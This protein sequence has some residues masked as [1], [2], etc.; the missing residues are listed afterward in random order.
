MHLYFMEW[1]FSVLLHKVKRALHLLSQMK[2]CPFYIKNGTRAAYIRWLR[3]S[4]FVLS[5]FSS[6]RRHRDHAC[7]VVGWRVV[8]SA[9]VDTKERSK[10]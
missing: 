10:D 4:S 6:A 5:R 7:A 1:R 3:A 2:T 8:V 9:C